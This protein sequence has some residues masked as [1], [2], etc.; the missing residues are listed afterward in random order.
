M[1]HIVRSFI[2]VPL[3]VGALLTLLLAAYWLSTGAPI[4]DWV[5]PQVRLTFP[6]AIAA[7]LSGITFHAYHIT[8]TIGVPSHL[9][10]RRL[11]LTHWSNYV[12]VGIAGSMLW[13]II[14]FVTFG[15]PYVPCGCDPSALPDV[16]LGI[17]PL[18]LFL[19][20]GTSFLLWVFARDS[21]KSS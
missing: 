19:T 8:L 18:F 17:I 2:L 1:P 3:I 14:M 4:Y 5:E 9:V 6:W 15:R 11:G 13:T 21:G 20:G 7:Y 12:G 10:L 16:G